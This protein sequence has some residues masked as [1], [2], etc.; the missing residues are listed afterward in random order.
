MPI[1][2]TNHFPLSALLLLSLTSCKVLDPDEPGNLVPETVAEDSALPSF[3]TSDGV[4]LHASFLD[5]GHDRTAIILHGGPGADHRAYL[6]LNALANEMNIIQ[7]DQRGTGLSERVSADSID[8]DTYVQDIVDLLDAW[9][10]GP[11]VVIGHS[12]GGAYAALFASTWPERVSHLILLEPAALT[13]DAA[14][15]ANSSAIDFGDPNVHRYLDT[16]QYLSPR[17]A[18][19]QDWYFGVLLQNFPAAPDFADNENPEDV[20]FWRHG[21]LA[22]REINDWQGNFSD[23]TF[24]L[25]QA[26]ATFEAPTLIVAGTASERLGAEFQ[27]EFH[28]PLF[29]NV[30][31]QTVEGAGHFL[32]V[33]H[34]DETMTLIRAFLQEVEP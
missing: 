15:E 3:E 18:A 12:W 19:R 29:Q 4:L 32:P 7:F 10:D 2:V 26:L 33:F 13:I 34:A 30:E 9:A 25:T 22:N 31:F 6:S 24:D 17:S 20:P 14:D 1:A 21:M 23:P 28:V 5:G 16:T 11:V 8:G 27:Q